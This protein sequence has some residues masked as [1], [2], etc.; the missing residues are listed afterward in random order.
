MVIYRPTAGDL[1]K[2]VLG[3]Y[4]L[5]SPVGIAPGEWEGL[6]AVDMRVPRDLFLLFEIHPFAG[7]FSW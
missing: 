2:R 3:R 4:A 6:G 5:Q 7:E 1:A